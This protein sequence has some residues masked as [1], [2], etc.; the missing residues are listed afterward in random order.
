VCC[1][2]F[3][4]T[5]CVAFRTQVPGVTKEFSRTDRIFVSSRNDVSKANGNTVKST[6]FVM[7]APTGY[8]SPEQA[9]VSL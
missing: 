6:E 4:S 9:A 3:L 2:R 1:W 8:A 5:S 7:S